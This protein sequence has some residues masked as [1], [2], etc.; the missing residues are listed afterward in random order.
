VIKSRRMKWARHV[1]RM[2]DRRGSYRDL[3]GRYERKS[4]LVKL[5]S[6][7]KGNIKMVLEV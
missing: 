6:E 4:S 1:A 3:V 2:G 7:W 5:S